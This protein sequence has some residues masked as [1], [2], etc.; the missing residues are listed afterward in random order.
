MVKRFVFLALFLGVSGLAYANSPDS[1]A[2]NGRPF[3]GGNPPFDWVANGLPNYDLCWT[4]QL[5]DY[6][7][8]SVSGGLWCSSNADRYW[9]FNGGG[10]ATLTQ[11][12]P[13]TSTTTTLTFDY[14]FEFEDPSMDYRDVLYIT[15]KD[16][17]ANTT[18]YYNAWSGS[19]GSVCTRNTPYLGTFSDINGH[20][21][22][23]QFI[24]VKYNANT[25][26]RVKFVS[27][28]AP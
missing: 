14:Q 17:T 22:Q 6:V 7:D 28:N 4:K 16:L 3:L 25:V 1:C 11:T 27:L 5:V 12:I 9:Q 10:T 15:V 21:L 23:V 20:T 26:I 2:P 8:P 24:A 19:N 13:I 18:M